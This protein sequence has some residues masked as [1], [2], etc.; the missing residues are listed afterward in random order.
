[1]QN[2][3]TWHISILNA[4]NKHLKKP[5]DIETRGPWNYRGDFWSLSLS[6]NNETCLNTD[7][8]KCIFLSGKKGGWRMVRG[9]PDFPEHQQRIHTAV[10]STCCSKFN[11][12]GQT[13]AWT[14]CAYRHL[15]YF[16][17]K[18]CKPFSP[19]RHASQTNFLNRNPRSKVCH[20]VVKCQEGW[21]QTFQRS[22][23][24]SS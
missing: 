16:R 9:C 5:R 2:S 17:T 11:A 1:M 13:V 6:R 21:C 8:W 18:Q 7:I 4:K 20:A 15:L 12:K 24:C 23:Y 14:L 22:K 3:S 10:S 19:R